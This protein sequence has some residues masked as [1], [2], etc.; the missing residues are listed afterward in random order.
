MQ[1]D[2][3][4]SKLADSPWFWAYVFSAAALI[5]LVLAG[6]KYLPRQAQL[7]RRFLARQMG[8]QTVK[9]RGGQTI[10]PPNEDHLILTL[11]PLFVICGTLL[12]VAWSRFW[13]T[14]WRTRS[15]PSEPHN[16]RGLSDQSRP[17][18]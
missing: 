7:E 12:V 2:P 16:D 4:R 17:A 8:G 13:L 10:Q 11:G 3:K 5:A 1:E 14:R 9:G 18:D 15:A 6:P